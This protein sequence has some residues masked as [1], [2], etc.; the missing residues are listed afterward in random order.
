MSAQG[1]N[2]LEVHR[3]DRGLLVRITGRGT[4]RESWVL[5]ELTDSCLKGDVCSLAVDL[6]ASAPDSLPSL[7]ELKEVLRKAIASGRPT[8]IELK[9]PSDPR[10]WAGIWATQGFDEGA[11]RASAAP[12]ASTGG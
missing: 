9:L 2:S 4:M 3:T 7:S 8:L 5:K 12:T 1:S 11:Q 6:S 10:F